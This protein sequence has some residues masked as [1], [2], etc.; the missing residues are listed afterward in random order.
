[1]SSVAKRRVFNTSRA[2]CQDCELQFGPY[3]DVGN[4]WG[5]ASRHA[6]SAGHRVLA[7]ADQIIEFSGNRAQVS[8]SSKEVTVGSLVELSFDLSEEALGMDTELRW[9][10]EHQARREVVGLAAQHLVVFGD[11]VL[12]Q[13]GEELRTSTGELLHEHCVTYVFPVIA[14]IPQETAKALAKEA[15]ARDR[16]AQGTSLWQPE[17]R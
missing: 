13:W 6:R 15:V 8:S 3:A 1:M 4:A 9:Q 5:N 2:M 17:P 10:F 7:Y 11:P 12:K 14:C 16:F